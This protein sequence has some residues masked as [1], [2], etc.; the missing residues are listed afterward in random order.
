M[1][2]DKNLEQLIKNAG[3]TE[4]IQENIGKTINLENYA[5][6]LNVIKDPAGDPILSPE[7]FRYHQASKAADRANENL[8]QELEKKDVGGYEKAVHPVVN[9]LSEEGRL[10]YDATIIQKIDL[11]KNASKEIKEV[12]K[13]LLLAEELEKAVEKADMDKIDQ[14]IRAMGAD[15]HALLDRAEL[16]YMRGYNR[17]GLLKI[18]GDIV[19]VNRGV[20]YGMLKEKKE[21]QA[22]AEKYI[23]SDPKLHAFAAK[24]VYKIYGSK[25]ESKYREEK[26]KK[27]A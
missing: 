16:A 9:E 22:E 3:I 23:A 1:T 4:Q 24:E 7:E 8:S 17:A 26:A 12:E 11:P 19:N 15:P 21:L 5:Y 27:S 13:R 25:Q 2:F 18:A 6:G 14:T 20:A 10:H